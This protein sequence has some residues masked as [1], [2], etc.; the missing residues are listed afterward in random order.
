[1]SNKFLNLMIATI[2]V[3]P[4]AFAQDFNFKNDGSIGS[5]LGM[6]GNPDP[7]LKKQLGTGKGKEI[8]IDSFFV[9]SYDGSDWEKGGKLHLINDD[10]MGRAFRITCSISSDDGDKF[11]KNA[12]RGAR[13]VVGLVS[14][15][16]TSYGLIIDPCVATD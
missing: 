13:K 7:L 15:Y 1:M 14:S 2:I 11:M 9:W 3:A 4:P 6:F 8:K 10:S 5:A 16:S 12:K